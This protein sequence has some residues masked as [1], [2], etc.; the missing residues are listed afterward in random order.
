MERRIT[1]FTLVFVLS[2]S[3]YLLTLAPTITWKHDGDDGGDLV[4]AVV[5]GGVPHPPGYPTYL[6]LGEVFV[7]IPWGDFARRMNLM[8]AVGASAAAGLTALAVRRLLLRIRRGASS[9]A[10]AVSSGLVLAFS[11]LLWS[12]AVI[13]EVYAPAVGFVAAMLLGALEMPGDGRKAGPLH[14]LRW[15]FWLWGALGGLGVGAHPL[16]LVVWAPVVALAMAR[17]RPK[18]A[19]AFGGGF[20][21]GLLCFAVLPLRAAGDPPVN[22]GHADTWEGFWWLVSGKLYHHY[23]FGLPWEFWPRRVLAWGSLM[24]RQFTPVGAILAFWGLGELWRLDR[25]LAGALLLSLVA[26]SVY[27]I[28]YNTSDSYVYLTF[29]LPV[30]ALAFGVGLAAALE[31]L[32]KLKGLRGS[33]KG[34]VLAAAAVLPAAQLLLNWQAVDL[35]GDQEAALFGECVMSEAPEDAL[36]ISGQDAHTFTLW[37][38]HYALGLRRDVVVVDRDLLRYNW[39]RADLAREP[40]MAFLRGEGV[41][42][43]PER[44]GEL[45]PGRRLW[46]VDEAAATRCD[47]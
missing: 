4:T 22:W 46:L 5:T 29:T 35:S 15:G 8:S 7:R 26:T 40:G 37:Y 23:V 36:V 18:E 39:Y 32:E 31:S 13:A 42:L 17:A 14:R 1:A 6:L 43:E 20:L 9:F 12:Q 44:W 47:Y 30:L 16:V 11:P 21:S 45:L 19:L 28:G 38:F 33:R 10:V 25:F 24:V 41:P 34:L 3:V 2:L 27:A